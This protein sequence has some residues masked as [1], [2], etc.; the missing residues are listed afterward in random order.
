MSKFHMVFYT[1][2]CSPVFK[3]FKSLKQLDIFI[4]TFKSDE[5]NWIFYSIT[6]IVGEFKE[7]S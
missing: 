4:K 5:D 3:K 1:K 6:N 7:Y 2:K